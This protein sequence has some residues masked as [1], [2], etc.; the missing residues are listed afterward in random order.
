[1]NYFDVILI[2]IISLITIRGLF[3]GLITELMTLIALILGFFI[4][5]F[6]LSDF[7][8]LLSGLFSGLPEVGA[9]IIAFIL[10]FLAVN[11]AVRL[12]S[13]ML[14]QFAKFT[15]LQP[16]NKVAGAIFAFTKILL[17]LSIFFLF[18]ELIP[19]SGMLLGKLNIDKSL[20]F[21]P[22]KKVAPGLY[23][24]LT[25]L[26]PGH[27]HIYNEF[28]NLFNWADTTAGDVLHQTP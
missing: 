7:S 27:K 6:Y 10:L 17:I 14:N 18:I 4:A 28:M 23:N 13:R 16:V 20:L 8:R 9:R 26:V 11:L 21:H 1:M 19:H 2:I 15:F 25:Y 22:I 5:T 3:R 12:L 24:I